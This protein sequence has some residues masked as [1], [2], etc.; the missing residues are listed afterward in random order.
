MN[1]RQVIRRSIVLGLVVLLGASCAPLNVQFDNSHQIFLEKTMGDLDVVTKVSSVV[2]TKKSLCFVSM[3]NDETLDSPVTA[4]VEDIILTQ[5][6]EAGYTVL[7]RDDDLI[8]RLIG[9]NSSPN[10]Q[11]SFFPKS[12]EISNV[13]AGLVGNSVGNYSAYGAVGKTNIANAGRDS[14]LFIETNMAAADFIVSYRILECGLIYRDSENQG[15][16]RREA[17]IRL[18]IRVHDA[19]TG[20][21]VLA[22]NVE[23]RA[24]DD[25]AAEEIQHLADFH[26]RF[27]SN[28]FPG[29]G[30]VTNQTK[31]VPGKG[32]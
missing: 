6:V 5:F 24:T 30:P 31:Y 21:I 14:I 29:Q 19:K 4:M 25:I 3:E 10:Y 2:S 18:H 9:E 22:S 13:Q 23:S 20:K 1:K 17:Q 15:E 12:T 16:V 32:R 27:F 26:Y 8:R 7:E 11:Y 28:D